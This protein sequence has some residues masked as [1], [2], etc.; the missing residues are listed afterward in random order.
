MTSYPRK[1][2]KLCPLKICTYTVGLLQRLSLDEVTGNSD[3][4]RNG[5]EIFFVDFE[6]GKLI[7]SINDNLTGNHPDNA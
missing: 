2:Q 3:E 4:C 7:L 1:Q 5:G 6:H